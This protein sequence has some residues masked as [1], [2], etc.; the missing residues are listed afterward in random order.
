MSRLILS[1]LD[2]N[3]VFN[4]VVAVEVVVAVS[5]LLIGQRPARG[6]AIKTLLLPA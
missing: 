6:K 3:L 4:V 1:N 5:L 2:S